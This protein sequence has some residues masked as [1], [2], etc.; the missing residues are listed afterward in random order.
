MELLMNKTISGNTG[1]AEDNCVPDDADCME[2]DAADVPGQY[3]DYDQ[4]YNGNGFVPAGGMEYAMT[5]DTADEAYDDAYDDESN[6]SGY[7]GK[8]AGDNT[9]ISGGK[10]DFD[11]R[12]EEARQNNAESNGFTL[13][14]P[15]NPASVAGPNIFGLPLG[16]GIP[17]MGQKQSFS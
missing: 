8:S 10:D 11:R 17:D 5:P 6:S 2:T 15:N 16:F 4:P 7:G 3:E 9:D 12:W 1:H 13:P 14:M